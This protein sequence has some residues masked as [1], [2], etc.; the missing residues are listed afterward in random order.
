[1]KAWQNLAASEC[2]IELMNKLKVLNLGLADVEEFNLGIKVNFRSDKS[3]EKL[4]RG[5][6]K[7]VKAAMDSKCEDELAKNS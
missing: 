1:M 5:E 7:L 3:R 2:R 4:E 6:N